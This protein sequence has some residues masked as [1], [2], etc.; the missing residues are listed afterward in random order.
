[1]DDDP[2]KAGKRIAGLKVLGN[3]SRLAEVVR[4]E[5]IRVVLIAIPSAHGRKIR[6]LYKQLAPLGVEVRLL[7]SLRELA[8]GAVSVTRL[9][10][11]KLEDLLGRDPIR[12]DL[13]EDANYIRD[14]RVLV[15]GAGGSIGSEIVR[16]VI[17]NKPAEL[18]VLGHGEQIGRA[19]V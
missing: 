14:R 16:Q 19:H 15:T 3:T 4:E 11:V 18:L 9:R 12:I 8:G 17:Q 13:D 10:S 7:P 5:G 6:S 2:Q 1:M